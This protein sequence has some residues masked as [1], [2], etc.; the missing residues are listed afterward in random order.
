MTE[1]HKIVRT[2]DRIGDGTTKKKGQNQGREN[3]FGP[4]AV[5]RGMGKVFFK[6]FPGYQIAR[7]YKEYVYPCEA[8]LA[9]RKSSMENQNHENS[10][11]S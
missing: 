4:V 7:E 2:K 6:E 11:T 1:F 10:Y 3:T 5:E 8:A 9:P